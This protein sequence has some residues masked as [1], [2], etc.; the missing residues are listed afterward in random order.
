MATTQITLE[1]EATSVVGRASR[2]VVVGTAAVGPQ[3]IQG[4]QGVQG[5]VGPQGTQGPQGDKGDKGDQ[6]DQ[7]PQGN[8]GPQGTQGPKGDKGDK[9]DQ[10]DQGPQG[11]VGPQGTQGPQGPQGNVGP[12]GTQGPQGPSGVISVNDPITNSGTSTSADLGLS[13]GDGLT[14]SAG[15]LVA[16]FGATSTTVAAG[17]RGLPTGGTTGQVL[18]KT[19]G[20]DYASG[21]SDPSLVGGAARPLLTGGA[22]LDGTGLVLSG[23]TGNYASAPDS[24]A[25]DITGDIDIKVKAT[26]TDWTPSANQSLVSKYVTSGNQISYFLGVST[27]GALR[28][29]YNSTGSA[30]NNNLV[31]SS[32]TGFTDGDTKWVRVTLDVDNGSSQRAIKFY[33]S[34][35]GTVWTQL[36]TTTVQAGTTSIFAGTASLEV[37][38]VDAGQGPLSGKVSRVIIQDA[39]DTV[40]NTTNVVFD[41][42]FSTQTADALA[43]TESSTNAATVT[44]NTTRYTYGYPN[45]GYT[46]AGTLTLAAN[47]DQGDP[48][49][50]TS[51]VIVDLWGI[52]VLTA[53]ASNRTLHCGLYRADNNMQPFGTA[54]LTDSQT[55]TANVNGAFRKQISPVTLQPGRYVFVLNSSDNIACRV[56][57]SSQHVQLASGLGTSPFINRLTVARTN[58]AFSTPTPFT[59]TGTA[60]SLP[61]PLNAF[62]RWKAA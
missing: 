61:F 49:F 42:D 14:T 4:P 8:V 19:S 62:F 5:N 45:A 2:I 12:Q 6:G 18:A 39:F 21:W 29:I 16:D 9:G 7:G 30:A 13:L 32:N 22:F 54:L 47:T 58:A 55:I 46:A 41:A 37:G 44:I 25:L 24:A 28:F 34:D 23:L 27:A 53:T 1:I 35:D 57:L 43:F 20:T 3:G 51:P 36:G 50:V 59:S 60:S 15:A 31:V 52:E 38:T 11:N 48:I 40:D 26:L 56:W 17:D 10:G 33:T